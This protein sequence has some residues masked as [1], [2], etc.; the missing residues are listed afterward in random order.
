MDARQ[1]LDERIEAYLDGTLEGE[2]ARRFERDLVQPEVTAALR[3]AL[4]L[5]EI[6][7]STLP[8]EAPAGLAGRI[9]RELGVAAPPAREAARGSRF[10]VARAALGGAAWAWRGPLAGFSAG[11]AAELTAGPLAETA[12]EGLRPI[13][14]AMRAGAARV[15]RRAPL[16]KVSRWG[17]WLRAIGLG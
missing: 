4:L 2:E 11:P 5:R 15:M 14:R 8:D 17:G 10:P 9:E 12:A 7:R 6:L 3:E 16:G 13:G 1:E